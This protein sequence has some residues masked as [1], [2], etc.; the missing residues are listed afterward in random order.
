MKFFTTTHS[1]L[2]ELFGADKTYAIPAY[3]RPY[4]WRSI[5]KTDQNNQ[6]NRMWD[7]LWGFFADNDK[8]KEY[9]FGSMVVIQKEA[10]VFEV[11]DGQQRLTTL[12]LLFGAMRCFIDTH[13][14]AEELKSFRDDSLSTL[15]KILY[16]SSGVALIQTLKVK[17]RRATGYDYNEV[18]ERAVKCEPASA[19]TDPQYAE[20][21]ERYFENRDYLRDRLEAAFLTDGIFTIADAERFNQF[22][23]FLYVRVAIVLITTASFET[24][25][26]I[27][28]TLNNRGLPLSNVDLLR[29]FLL[30]KLSEAKEPDA[31]A[32]WT[33]L[34]K[35]AL[36]EEFM[37]RWVESWRAQQQRSSAFNDLIN[38]YDDE[39]TFQSIPGKPRVRKFYETIQRDLRYYSLIADPLAR[40]ENRA[41]RNK[42]RFL[43]VA[44][45]ERYSSNLM[46]ALFRYLDYDGKE[47]AP[48]LEFLIAYQRWL[49]HV[50]L[51]PSMRFSNGNIY[52]SIGLIRSGD[53]EGAKAIFSL[54]VD[55]A[56]KLSDYLGGEHRDNGTAKL[57]LAEY[58]WHEEAQVHDVV[59]QELRWPEASLEHIIPQNPD[60]KSRWVKDFPKAF[61]KDFTY[62]LG[63]MTLVTH[64]MNSSAKNYEFATK[65]GHYKKTFLQL[66]KELAALDVLTPQY[67]KQRHERIVAGLRAALGL[68]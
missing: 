49:V 55:D 51:A 62:R 63:N 4:S 65:K 47:S 59:T 41:I 3:Q 6:V 67:I 40:V 34:E 19:I 43:R 64:K 61:R 17:I 33:A 50:L 66:T 29:N 38:T 53:I 22:F 27:F 42:I 12:A 20:I 45:N 48:A 26:M 15:R 10:R 21:A 60:A 39:K 54:G 28:E 18:L 14:K 16:N 2:E 56:A 68:A 32:M 31:A 44:G 1:S 57:L 25:F 9:F 36:T 46:L 30:E 58:V 13:C 52:K 5:G 7:D 24:A 23:S 11:V 37:G 35:D 8:E